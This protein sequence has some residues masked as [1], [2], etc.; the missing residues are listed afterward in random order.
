MKNSIAIV[1]GIVGATL[2]TAIWVANSVFVHDQVGF[3]AIAV[4]LF[5]G[6]A[7]KHFV[8]K[9]LDEYY[10]GQLGTIACICT[11]LALFC[12]K[13]WVLTTHVRAIQQAVANFQ[14][15]EESFVACIAAEL[16]DEIESQGRSAERIKVGASEFPNRSQFSKPVWHVAFVT[17]Q[18]MDNYD[19]AQLLVAAR[20][21]YCE[22][23]GYAHDMASQPVTSV[24]FR[25]YL[26][27]F[28]FT[29]LVWFALSV[30][31][32]FV[33]ATSSNQV[34]LT[35]TVGKSEVEILQERVKNAAAFFGRNAKPLDAHL[36]RDEYAEVCDEAQSMV[37]ET[38]RVLSTEVDG[39]R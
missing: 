2:G 27:D 5:S 32:A 12:G 6:L 4:G 16:S 31:A 9:D 20:E 14:P 24:A 29:N 21:Y 33:I 39:R 37:A 25:N 15:D 13:Y 3:S 28:G 18:G 17:W 35:N 36:H 30:A 10:R 26:R 22:S 7:I 34:S 19:K 11:L 8:G 23:L 38:R 1:Y